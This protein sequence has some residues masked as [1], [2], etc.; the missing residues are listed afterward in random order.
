MKT[1]I[2]HTKIWKDEWFA[3]LSKDAKFL[4]L[5]LLT[6][7]KLNIS[8][9]YELTDREMT[10]DLGEDI[11]IGVK[12]ELRPKAMF[13]KNWVFIPNIEK[14][15]SYRNAPTN[16]KAFEKEILSIPNDVIRMILTDTSIDTSIYTPPILQEIINKKSEIINSKL[17][18]EN[19]KSET[20]DKTE[21]EIKDELRTSRAKL[22]KKMRWVSS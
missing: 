8:G 21:E 22:F 15:N 3:S 10:F 4:W 2:I 18:I 11:D 1:R 5:Y 13:Y 16:Q 6:N 20:R 14:Y 19:Q 17:E 9:I 12:E 7:E